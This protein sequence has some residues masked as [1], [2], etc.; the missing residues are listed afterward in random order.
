MARDRRRTTREQFTFKLLDLY[1]L[2]S[3]SAPI[4]LLYFKFPL[5]VTS[6]YSY[7][8]MHLLYYGFVS[9][10]SVCIPEEGHET[11]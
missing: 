4:G 2:P 9:H 3:S 5:W 10:F 8:S 6:F 1:F 7:G 11:P